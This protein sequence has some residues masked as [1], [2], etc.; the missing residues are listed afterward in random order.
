MITFSR[1]CLFYQ[2]DVSLLIEPVK[3]GNLLRIE[4]AV[5]DLEVIINEDV[6]VELFNH[7]SLVL[8]IFDKKH[9][10]FSGLNLVNSKNL[11]S[12][13]HLWI[14]NRIS[15]RALDTTNTLG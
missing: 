5:N 15:A 9:S 10:S 4:E 14:R 13:N 8:V 2:S 3:V 11:F 6:N 1:Y 12:H 7:T